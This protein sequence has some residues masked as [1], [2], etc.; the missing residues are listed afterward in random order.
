MHKNYTVLVVD[1][2]VT[3][4]E[5]VKR[6]LGRLDVEVFVASKGKEAISVALDR[7]V[8]LLI[9]DLILPG[10]S[11]GE[12]DLHLQSLNPLMETIKM[13]GFMDLSDSTVAKTRQQ[14]QFKPFTAEDLLG[15]VGRFMVAT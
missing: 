14:F 3:I 6:V 11:G 5:S 7:T 4:L 13:S 10:M 12:L 15:K 9:V 1:D 8:D 2:D